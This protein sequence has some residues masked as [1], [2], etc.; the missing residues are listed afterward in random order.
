MTTLLRLGGLNTMASLS[1]PVAA[2]RP[3]T[4]VMKAGRP[5]GR[6]A[7]AIAVYRQRQ[8]RV[9]STRAASAAISPE[10]CAYVKFMRDGPTDRENASCPPAAEDPA[11]VLYQSHLARAVSTFWSAASLCGW[12][13]RSGPTPPGSGDGGSGGAGGSGGSGN[14][15]AGSG[16]SDQNGDFNKIMLSALGIAATALILN[17]MPVFAR[18]KADTAKDGKVCPGPTACFCEFCPSCSKTVAPTSQGAAPA[19]QP[20]R[21]FSEIAEEVVENAIFSW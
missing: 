10:W 16:G 4:P 7:P 5:L 6:A 18:A 19:T 21:T 12:F 11:F 14:D 13:C 8:H 15:G 3:V 20:T 17:P 9:I 2:C 1:R